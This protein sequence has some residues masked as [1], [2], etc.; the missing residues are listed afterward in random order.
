MVS[1]WLAVDAEQLVVLWVLVAIVTTFVDVVEPGVVAVAIAG[2][3]AVRAGVHRGSPGH[4]DPEDRAIEE[5]QRAAV[6]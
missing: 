3:I 2:L 5:D 1:D 6:G 4:E